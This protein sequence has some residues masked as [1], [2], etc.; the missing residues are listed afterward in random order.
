MWPIAEP[1]DK[2]FKFFFSGPPG[3]YKTRLALRLAD[4]G[5]RKDPATGII[6][7][8]FGTDHY[9]GEFAFRRLQENDPD[10]IEEEILK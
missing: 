7:T 9:A 1:K 10:L 8:E 6:D 4:N 3:S 2:K 5:N